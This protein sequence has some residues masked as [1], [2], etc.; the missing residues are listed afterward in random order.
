MTINPVV[1]GEY[2]DDDQKSLVWLY[3]SVC[4]NICGEPQGNTVIATV[5][6]TTVNTKPRKNIFEKKIFFLFFI[7]NILKS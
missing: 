7:K 3:V 1:D 4:L 5:A 2:D 6:N